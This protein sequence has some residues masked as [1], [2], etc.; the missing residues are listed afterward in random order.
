MSKML[1]LLLIVCAASSVQVPCQAVETWKAGVGR[2][3]IT[4]PQPMPM[5]GYASRG[6][7]HATGKFQDLWAKAIML[8]DA[9]GKRCVIVTL[10]LCGIDSVLSMRVL[11]RLKQ[12]CKLDAQQV[13]L[14]TSHTHSGP[15]VAGNLR[16]MHYMLFGEEDRKLV[17]DYATALIEKITSAVQAAE[18]D[19]RPSQLR[20]GAGN[21]NF[22]VNRRNNPENEVPTRRANNTLVGPSD[23]TVPVLTV[24]SEG[25]LRAL[26]FGYACHSTTLSGMDW[27]G[28]Y[29]G[30]AQDELESKHPGCQ[31]MFWAGC[32][33]DQNPIPRRTVELAREYGK[34]LATAVNTVVAGELKEISPTL[35]VQLEKV[36]VPFG[37]LPTREQLEKDT[38]SDNQ[39]TA[40]RAQAWLRELDQGKSLPTTYPYP[41]STWRL[42]KEVDW[43]A[44]GGEV[45]VDYA[46]SIKSL[47][48]A[49]R[50]TWVTAYA[51]D[52]MAY[53]PS[54]RV[55]TEGGY[56]GG[57]AMVYY[58]QP[59]IW[60]PAIEQAILD[61]TSR[62]LAKP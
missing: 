39:Y 1:W 26:V 8:E 56:E 62:Q 24:S 60:A 55:L 46:L 38:K 54:R 41:I 53:I 30:F 61:E 48:T 2:E 18:K 37:D 47:P 17:D 13:M 52:V 23:H 40:S 35:S 11:E 29:P 31:A 25:K 7:A 45:V 28:D 10:D 51:N 6:A 22:A 36:P 4:P 20:Y 33:G 5:A 12:A 34:R 57:G 16:P 58:G 14:A 3:V 43:V 50:T 32:G 21:E 15:V 19:L 9:Q 42:G 59:T 49:K 44:L 27:S